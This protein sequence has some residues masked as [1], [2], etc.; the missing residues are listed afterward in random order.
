MSAKAA[1]RLDRL[2]VVEGQHV[3]EGKIIAALD[4]SNARAALALAE[5]Q[6]K[7]ARASVRKVDVALANA[8]RELARTESLA[9]GGF[10]SGAQA[11]AA[12]RAVDSAT[13]QRD[14]ALRNEDVSLRAIDVRAPVAR[15]HDG[16]RAVLRRRHRAQR[17]AGRD[18]LADQWR[19][20]SASRCCPARVPCARCRNG[21]ATRA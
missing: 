7:S 20:S 14:T 2:S 11:E 6:R 3:A 19:W 17:G 21:S 12:R 8:R 10:V 4:D 18:R 5:A 15:R 1:G 13:A 16:A 9:A